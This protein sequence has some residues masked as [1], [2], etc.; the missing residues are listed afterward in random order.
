MANGEKVSPTDMELA[1]TGDPLFEQVMVIGEARPFL[2]ALAVLN[3]LQWR[4]LVQEEGLQ[5]AGLNDRNAENSLLARIADLLH[6]FPGYAQVIRI[7]S[8]LEPWTVEDGLLTPTLKVKRKEIQEK[9]LT[10]V[11]SLYEG[12]TV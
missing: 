8:T 1:I 5:E 3:K 9:F 11:D 2:V 12:H 6:E 10:E 4:Q 7:H